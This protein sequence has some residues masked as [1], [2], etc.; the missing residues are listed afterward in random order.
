VFSP[1]SYFPAP[2]YALQG[3]YIFAPE[4]LSFLDMANLLREQYPQYPLPSKNLPKFLVYLVGPFVASFS[5][6]YIRHNVNVPHEFSV[7]KA[8]K[9]LNVEFRPVK[10]GMGLVVC[11][12][13]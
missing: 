7:E 10:Q 8:K 2:F 5:W 4:M 9:E 6:H 13:V 11:W 12:H 3:R 1:G